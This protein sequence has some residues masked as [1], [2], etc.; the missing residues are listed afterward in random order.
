VQLEG[1]S[2]LKNP[3]TPIGNQTLDFTAYSI[4][5]KELRYHMIPRNKHYSVMLSPYYIYYFVVKLVWVENNIVE[6]FS[7]QFQFIYDP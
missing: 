1:L 6:L 2:Q 7:V 4:A 3:V 5:L